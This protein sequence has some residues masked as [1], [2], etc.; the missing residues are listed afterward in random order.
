MNGL[1]D[2]VNSMTM[3]VFALEL[4][5][6]LSVT[7]PSMGLSCYRCD[8]KHNLSCP[9]WTRDPVDTVKDLGD[10]NGLY[11]HCVTVTLKDGTIV[12]QNP[13]PGNTHCKDKFV[14]SWQYLLN[15][16]Y[17]QEVEVLCCEG[18]TCNGNPEP[19]KKNRSAKVEASY[20]ALCGLTAMLILASQ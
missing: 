20:L 3:Y 7:G 4:L 8:V 5:T 14:E 2:L 17:N 15:Q 19:I 12:E 16:E 10:N 13:Y 6:L 1:A 18:D 9:G 11:T